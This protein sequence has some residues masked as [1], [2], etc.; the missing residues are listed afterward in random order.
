MFSNA[1][2]QRSRSTTSKRISN[3]ALYCKTGCGFFGNQAWDGYCS[4]CYKEANAKEQ[5]QQT[6]DVAA[7][8]Q[9][10]DVFKKDT[11]INESPSLRFD[12]FE[13]KKKQK[14]DSKRDSVKK[15]FTKSPTVKQESTSPIPTRRALYLQD[16]KEEIK[17]TS[18]E[19]VEFLK[20][21]KRPASKDIKERSKEFIFR[22]L[23]SYDLPIDKQSEMVQ[24]FYTKMA[25]R[26]QTNPSF[27]NMSAE[28][29]EF[30][31]DGIEKYIMTHI[32]KGVFCH[33]TAGDEKK[34]L[35]L[36][37]RLH[38]LNWI[39]WEQLEIPVD[40]DA[41]EIDKLMRQTQTELLE[42][43]SKRAPQDKLA[44]IVKC[45]LTIFRML[46]GGNSEIIASA[47][48]FLP[49][50]IYVV[51]K[52]NPPLLHS[53][54][55]YITRFCNPNKL[56]AGEGGYYF[57]NLC[58]AVSFL[59]EL[60]AN[61]LSI[62][63]DEF[64]SYMKG[65]KPL[66]AKKIRHRRYTVTCDGLEGMQHNLEEISQLREL[67]SK[68]LEQCRTTRK[69]M[70]EFRV[71][72]AKQIADILQNKHQQNELTHLQSYLEKPSDVEEGKLI[73]LD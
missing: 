51:L 43:N 35:E 45:S 34:D 46:Q 22:I 17:S 26:I 65:E 10:L 2:L 67:Q 25:N 57:T 39:T 3:V 9:S 14:Q 59:K 42:M 47:D 66:R 63:E 21:L 71:N 29:I 37:R 4:K 73:D 8:A 72:V 33:P 16:V 50:L 69:E 56:M 55:Q 6:Q 40:F 31:M 48:D 24:D 58:C 18:N 70:D 20:A 52:T 30:M 53:N 27:N 68:T 36:Q 5:Q 13:E 7:A 41:P 11:E 32:Y 62:S 38:S 12:K 23:Q 28:K 54:I 61:S 49:I 60:D 19:F 44:C 1:A 64:N 15:F